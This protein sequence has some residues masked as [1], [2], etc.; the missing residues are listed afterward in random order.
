MMAGGSHDYRWCQCIRTSDE[1][2]VTVNV[3]SLSLNARGAWVLRPCQPE[4][5]IGAMVLA[6]GVDLMEDFGLNALWVV[7]TFVDVT[8]AGVTSA[9]AGAVRGV[10]SGAWAGWAAVE[11]QVAAAGPM[12]LLPLGRQSDLHPCDAWP[13]RHRRGSRTRCRQSRAKGGYGCGPVGARHS[14]P[15]HSIQRSP[16]GGHE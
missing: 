15:H 14:S 10:V 16:A 3:R 12:P 6:S 9:S 2:D 8:S 11:A 7:V 13:S 5:V 4:T 1:T